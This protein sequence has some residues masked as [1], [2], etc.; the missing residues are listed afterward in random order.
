M[1]FRRIVVLKI[2]SLGAETDQKHNNLVLWSSTVAPLE[3]TGDHKHRLDGA[4]TPIVVILWKDDNKVG[5]LWGMYGKFRSTLREK[6]NGLRQRE[7]KSRER[8]REKEQGEAE[9]EKEQGEAER[10]REK[11]RGRGREKVRGTK[12]E[13]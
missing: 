10:E 7:R 12:K 9:R 5:V 2:K 6:V 1:N 13:S 8:Q 11:G 3:G 4:K